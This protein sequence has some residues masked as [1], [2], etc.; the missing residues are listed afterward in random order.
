M[1]SRSQS[2]EL[3]VFET[4]VVVHGVAVPLQTVDTR[5]RENLYEDE[6]PIA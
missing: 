1:T 6:L 2:A 5:Q 3:L 4:I